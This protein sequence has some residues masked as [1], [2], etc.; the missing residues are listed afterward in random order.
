MNSQPI[1]IRR[2]VFLL[3]FM[4]AGKTTIGRHLAR[5]LGWTFTDLDEAVE[6]RQ[7]RTIVQIFAEDGEAAFRGYERAALEE[8]LEATAKRP[9]VVALGGGTVAQPGNGAL[10]QSSSGVTVWLDCSLDELQRRCQE[11]ANRP[12][13]QD[14][15][16]FRQLYEQRR[17]YYEQADF[18][19]DASP[20][21]PGA[22]VEEI[23]RCI[24][25]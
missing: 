9:S 18:R 8:V 17:P 4:G 25:F 14:A 6:S 16:H 15:A 22:V 24:P 21:D 2:R 20:H 3:G 12:L 5:Q 13:F 10:L 7:K 11:M 19:V 23:I 1:P